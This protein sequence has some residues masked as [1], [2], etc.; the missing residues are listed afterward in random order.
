MTNL[1]YWAFMAFGWFLVITV[2]CLV[3]WSAKRKERQLMDNLE[4]PAGS[5]DSCSHSVAR[6]LVESLENAFGCICSPTD[7]Q[8]DNLAVA[9]LKMMCAG[10]RFDDGAIKE[11]ACGPFSR[12]AEQKY[13]KTE[14]YRDVEQLLDQIYDAAIFDEVPA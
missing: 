7:Q 8:L 3:W 13:G 5:N 6:S 1:A 10:V 4:A 2:F 14:G 11:I 9:V 12:E